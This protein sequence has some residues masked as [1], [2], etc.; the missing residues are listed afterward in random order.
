MAVNR[1]IPILI[2][3]D[4]KATLRILRN[5]L[6]QSGFRNIDEALNSEEA[7]SKLKEK[8]FGLVISDWDLAPMTG[9]ELLK[10]IRS[11]DRT[12]KTPFFMVA[13]EIKQENIVAAKDAGV[14]NFIIKPFS[15]DTI[16]SKLVGVFG[17]F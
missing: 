7:Q 10:S 15:S 4:N 5:L 12:K 8:L 17:P 13:S 16:K 2:V 9:L 1:N 11:D 6:G 3:D 14:T